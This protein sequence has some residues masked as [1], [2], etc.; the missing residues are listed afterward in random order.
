MIRIKINAAAGA[1]DL[2]IKGHA[3]YAEHGKDIVCAAVSTLFNTFSIILKECKDVKEYAEKIAPG[4][5]RIT[6]SY[7]YS[8]TIAA[9]IHAI[10]TGLRNIAEEHPDNV[11]IE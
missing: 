6:M 1:Y 5:S 7:R 2:I 4:D 9:Y 11:S 3:D 10:E 8:P